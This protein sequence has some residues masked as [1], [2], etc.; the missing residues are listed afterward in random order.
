VIKYLKRHK[1]VVLT[2]LI[3]ILIIFLFFSMKG[4]QYF[5]TITIYPLTMTEIT[6]TE[7]VSSQKY[8]PEYTMQLFLKELSKASVRENAYKDFLLKNN[9]RCK[10]DPYITFYEK[11]DSSFPVVAHHITIEVRSKCKNIS[12]R[13]AEF[14]PGYMNAMLA[15]KIQDVENIRI[16]RLKDDLNSKLEIDLQDVRK[17]LS[18][19]QE[20]L[21]KIIKLKRDENKQGVLNFNQ[22][23]I[24]KIKS[25]GV[26]PEYNV[27]IPLSYKAAE[28]ELN[29]LS[30]VPH[31]DKI[32]IDIINQMS[33]VEK[34]SAI[35]NFQGAK[36]IHS[37]LV[38]SE[39]LSKRALFLSLFFIIIVFCLGFL[40]TLLR[41]SKFK[42]ST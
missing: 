40:V 38:S 2:Q 24:L 14:L 25:K 27:T 18:N 42:K 34:H 31:S 19:R 1:G 4:R 7:G 26:N 11:S 9:T 3:F 12:N 13:F 10:D 21:S 36:F 28:A 39:A 5:S 20:I 30:S 6:F 8:T 17:F 32:S 22:N 15:N 37:S 35:Q 29:F 23:T 41:D 33:D 16:G